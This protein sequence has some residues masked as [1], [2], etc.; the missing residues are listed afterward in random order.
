MP[1]CAICTVCAVFTV[2]ALRAGRTPR[3][4][5]GVLGAEIPVPVFSDRRR[6]AVFTVCALEIGNGNEVFPRRAIVVRILNVPVRGAHIDCACS[7]RAAARACRFVDGRNKVLLCLCCQVVQ[8]A[9]LALDRIEPALGRLVRRLCACFERRN[10]DKIKFVGF[11]QRIAKVPLQFTLSKSGLV[12]IRARYRPIGRKALDRKRH[13]IR[14]RIAL[15]LYQK[16]RSAAGEYFLESGQRKRDPCGLIFSRP[17]K[18]YRVF[19]RSF[20][21]NHMFLLSIADNHHSVR[22]NGE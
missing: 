17:P 4:L 8:V 19:V 21:F 15:A 2:C 7:T 20:N 9:D 10:N 11:R 16:R 12:R 6:N 3:R 1:V 22:C 14:H 18:R 5:P 13:R